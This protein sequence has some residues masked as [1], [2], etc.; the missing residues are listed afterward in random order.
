MCKK[1]PVG[2]TISWKGNSTQ[3][4]LEFE[5]GVERT[6]MKKHVYSVSP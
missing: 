5:K 6:M 4:L 3:L 1:N 2:L